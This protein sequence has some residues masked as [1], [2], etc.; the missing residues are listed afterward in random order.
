MHQPQTASVEAYRGLPQPEPTLPSACYYDRQHHDRELSAI[1]YKDWLYVCRADA[2]DGPRSFRVFTIGNQEIL[3]LRDEGHRLQ[4]FHN[5]CRHRGSR[6]CTEPAGR[7]KTNAIQCP[8]HRWAY[9][10]QGDLLGFPAIA[11]VDDFNKTDY[12]LYRVGVTEWSACIFINV[13][14]EEA[15]P[16][17]TALRPHAERLANWLLADLA[18]GH[19]HRMTLACNW[20]LFWENFSECYHCPGVHPEL[21]RLVPIYG[22]SIISPYDDPDW[23]RHRDS[24]DPRHRGGL[25][26]G[27]E[28]WSMDGQVHGV[29]FPRLTEQER[30][31]GQTYI[32]AWPSMFVVGHVDYARVVSLRPLGPELIELTAEWL[33][34][35]ETLAQPGFDLANVVDFGRLV[36]EQ[37]G[38]ACELNQAGLHALAH[39]QGVLLPQESGVFVFQQWVRERLCHVTG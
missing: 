37:D 31:A 36:L 38:A 15:P 28:T 26:Q 25:R 24:S 6:L 39:K 9:S 19:T 14:G 34:P 29:T 21:S 7:L 4:A 22:R 8:Y 35:R 11:S 3:V 23:Q 13:S 20:K 1:W 18:I 27:A 12:P 33:F 16:F 5:T 2:L 17:E 30:R 10:L 32:T